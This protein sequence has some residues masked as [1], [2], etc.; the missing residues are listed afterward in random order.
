MEGGNWIQR[1]SAARLIATTFGVLSGIGGIIHGIGEVLQGNTPTGG[2]FIV[3]WSTGPIAQYIDGDPAITIVHNFLA[4][5]IL[6]IFAGL[7]LITWSAIYVG[8]RRGGLIQLGLA[9]VMMLFGGGGGP[10]MIGIV[11]SI[12]AMGIHSPF[13]FWQK[14]I[15]GGFRRFLAAIWPWVFGVSTAV[16]LFLVFGHILF[17]STFAEKAS[18]IFYNS[19]L[20]TVVLVLISTLVG[21]GFDLQRRNLEE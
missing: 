15:R 3:S 16:G 2:S 19:F 18:A 5:G 12:A 8:K 9:I 21:V 20:V 13:T 17:A 7:A 4:T 1:Q 11:A 10:P 6:A 14:I